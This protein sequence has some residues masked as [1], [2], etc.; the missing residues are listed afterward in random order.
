[1]PAYQIT[2]TNA[3]GLNPEASDALNTLVD[4]LHRRGIPV[5]KQRLVSTLVLDFCS[6]AAVDGFQAAVE[7][8]S[9]S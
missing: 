8:R 5:S 9:K 1:M 4:L 7:K 2:R 3:V 6:Q